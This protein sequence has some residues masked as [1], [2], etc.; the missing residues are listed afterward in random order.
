MTG[1]SL[2][3]REQDDDVVPAFLSHGVAAVSGAAL[4]RYGAEFL[5]SIG[6]IRPQDVYAV[7]DLLF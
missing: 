5:A 4:E 3:P 1:G 6:G 7:E 2:L